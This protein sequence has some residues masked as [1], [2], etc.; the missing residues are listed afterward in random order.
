MATEFPNPSDEI[1][2]IGSI[3]IT[4]FVD[5][6]LVLLVIF[7]VTAPM[8]LKDT[9]SVKLPKSASI[10]GKSA[11][12]I[13]ITVTK[14]GQI[15]LSGKPVL[16]EGLTVAVEE[17]RAKN[18]EASAIIA[19]DTEAKHGDVVRAIDWLKSAGVENFALQIERE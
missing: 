18:P 19:A 7:M 16:K 15:L 2:S 10:D 12:S 3:N 5:V 13:G 17:A 9:L 6:V 11:Q 14:D 8:I 4:P 1:T